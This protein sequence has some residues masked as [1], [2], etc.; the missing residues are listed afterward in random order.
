LAV[1]PR[2]TLHLA[3]VLIPSGPDPFLSLCAEFSTLASTKL[4][5]S[6]RGLRRSWGLLHTMRHQE[7]GS[8]AM[9]SLRWHKRTLKV[10]ACRMTRLRLSRSAICLVPATI[11]CSSCHGRLIAIDPEESLC[12]PLSLCLRVPPSLLLC[13]SP[14]PSFAPCVCQSVSLAPSPPLPYSTQAVPLSPPSW[15]L[16]CRH[17]VLHS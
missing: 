4:H 11:R 12:L 17:C 1:L 3:G 15:L 2:G 5:P 10:R 14:F 9:C 7:R 13:P 6:L 16:S 8:F